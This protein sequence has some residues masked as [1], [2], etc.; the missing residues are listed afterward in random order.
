MDNIS[1][2][3]AHRD[4]SNL[5]LCVCFSYKCVCVWLQFHVVMVTLSVVGFASSGLDLQDLS[6]S[7]YASRLG[8]HQ[9]KLQSFD[10]NL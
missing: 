10:T 8:K 9:Q 7:L 6:V 5:G 2:G 3:D 1:D 4:G